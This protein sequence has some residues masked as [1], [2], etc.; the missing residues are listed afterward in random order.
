MHAMSAPLHR[1]QKS[2]GSFEIFSV[3]NEYLHKAFLG[4]R[5]KHIYYCLLS[6][7]TI[8]GIGSVNFLSCNVSIAG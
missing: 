2:Y 3:E 4:F 8:F 6:I 1:T 5:L 7:I